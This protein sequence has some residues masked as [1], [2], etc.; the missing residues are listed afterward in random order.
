[1]ISAESELMASS[2]WDGLALAFVIEPSADLKAPGQQLAGWAVAGIRGGALRGRA[3]HGQQ[4]ALDGLVLAFVMGLSADLH[5]MT[6]S[7]LNGLSL[8]SVM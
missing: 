8:A 4:L 7:S 3:A 5:L 2:S 6:T 1:M